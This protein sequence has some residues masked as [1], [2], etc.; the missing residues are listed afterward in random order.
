M[1]TTRTMAL[2]APSSRRARFVVPLLA[3]AHGVWDTAFQPLVILPLLLLAATDSLLSTGIALFFYSS[4]GAISFAAGSAARIGSAPRGTRAVLG[5]LSALVLFGVALANA[6]TSPGSAGLTGYVPAALVLSFVLWSAAVAGHREYASRSSVLS[7]RT[8]NRWLLTGSATG[9]LAAVLLRGP[10]AYGDL[11]AGKTY[12]VPILLA[13]SA[14]VLVAIVSVAAGEGNTPRLDS[15]SSPLRVVAGLLGDNLAFGRL[16]LFQIV[17]HLGS[18][19]DPF[20]VVYALRELNAGGR[21]VI[22]YLLVLVIARSATLA[23]LRAFISELSNRTLLQLASFTRLVASVVALTV[24]P[25][26]NSAVIRDRLPSGGGTLLVAYAIVFVALGAAGAASDQATPSLIA[27]ITTQQERHGAL[28]LAR[29]NVGATSAVFILGALLAD[30]LGY[31]FLFIGALILGLTAL[32]S[33]G[34]VAGPDLIVLRPGPAARHE[35]RRR[36]HQA[37][38]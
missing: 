21:A 28:L 13:G 24:P 15:T 17:Y 5:L 22:S 6:L 19:A 25:L 27:S 32:L 23:V 20:F 18:L 14:A 12:I 8:I 37:P 10:L 3:F 33:S 35:L 4:A 16:L 38:D 1:A 11:T 34:L 9:I 29:L 2:P 31:P 7:A 26:L 30:R 36:H